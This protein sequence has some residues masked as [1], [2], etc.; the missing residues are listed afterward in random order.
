MSWAVPTMRLTGIAAA[1]RVSGRFRD[2]CDAGSALADPASAE[3]A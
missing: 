1:G 2:C 3:V